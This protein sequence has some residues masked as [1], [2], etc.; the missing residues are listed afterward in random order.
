MKNK[1][2]SNTYVF[3]IDYF[4]FENPYNDLRETRS[5]DQSLMGLVHEYHKGLPHLRPDHKLRPRPQ[6]KRRR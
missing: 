1:K 2:P 6:V 5:D 3:A 4:G